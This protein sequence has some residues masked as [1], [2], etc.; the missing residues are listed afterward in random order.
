[1]PIHACVRYHPSLL[2][3]RRRSEGGARKSPAGHNQ[4]RQNQQ[5]RSYLVPLFAD[6]LGVTHVLSNR[7]DRDIL[8]LIGHSSS[9]MRENK[10]HSRSG[11]D[12]VTQVRG[13]CRRVNPFR[14]IRQ[15]GQRVLS[16]S[17]HKVTYE[18]CAAMPTNQLG[19]SP[20][21]T[22]QVATRP[23]CIACTPYAFCSFPGCAMQ[24]GPVRVF[25][26]SDLILSRDDALLW[27]GSCRL[28]P[29]VPHLNPMNVFHIRAEP[30]SVVH[31]ALEE[32]SCHLFGDAP[33]RLCQCIHGSC[34]KT[35]HTKVDK[36]S[37]HRCH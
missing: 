3:L 22:R 21:P 27:P 12:A 14:E 23:S 20:G 28:D 15:C 16:C 35:P 31:L 30:S 6:E 37:N 33:A 17:S 36:S 26:C 9:R 8:P 25:R 1:M 32:Y 29:P 2:I 10:L 5:G 18:T 24:N 13:S 4:H 19:R 11:G 34:C 7:R